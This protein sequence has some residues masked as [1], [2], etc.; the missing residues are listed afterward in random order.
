MRLKYTME[1][2]SKANELILRE[3]TGID[4]ER[5][6]LLNETIYNS[7]KIVSAVSKSERELL[8]ALRTENMFPPD[9]FANRLFEMVTTLLNSKKRQC[10][11]I[12]VDDLDYIDKKHKKIK[13]R[14]EPIEFETEP[15]DVDE[16]LEEC[17]DDTCSL[18]NGDDNETDVF[19]EMFPF[20]EVA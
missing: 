2:K 3:Y 13:R 16:L 12:V 4:E 1:K 6:V 11:E 10:I 20:D 8:I 15:T 5:Y 19:Q 9:M 7:E 17:T 18:N 14:V